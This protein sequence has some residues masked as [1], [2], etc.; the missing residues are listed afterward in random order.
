MIIVKVL[1]I[2]SYTNSQLKLGLLVFDDLNIEL[3]FVVVVVC[4]C[5]LFVVIFVMRGPSFLLFGQYY[6]FHL[7][8]ICIL[9]TVDNSYQCTI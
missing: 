4:C 7:Y 6:I 1:I 2:I 3:L 5:L 8:F 9:D